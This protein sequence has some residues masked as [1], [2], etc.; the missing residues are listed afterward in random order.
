MTAKDISIHAATTCSSLA[1]AGLS[2]AEI[3]AVLDTARMASLA[4]FNLE[5]SFSGQ[6]LPNSLAVPKQ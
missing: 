1:A 2:S 6:E 3:I 4:Q 5:R